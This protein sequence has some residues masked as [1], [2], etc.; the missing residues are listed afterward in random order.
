MHWNPVLCFE[1][2]EGAAG[3][4]AAADGGAAATAGE[5]SSSFLFVYIFFGHC[6]W[7][8]SSRVVL[9]CQV[10]PAAP[11]PA[12]PMAV[13]RP[14][15]WIQKSDKGIGVEVAQASMLSGCTPGGSLI[16]MGG[17]LSASLCTVLNCDLH[18]HKP[19][20]VRR[21]VLAMLGKLLARARASE[22]TFVFNLSTCFYFPK[23]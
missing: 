3:G 17:D 16:V 15:V 12:Q 9:R 20:A 22:Q 6:S 23:V 18:L 1:N 4:H 19:R 8:S 14:S 11:V 7:D 2:P 13:S 21:L 10:E 5:A